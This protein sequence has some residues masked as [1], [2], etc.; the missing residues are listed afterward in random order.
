MELFGFF[1]GLPS[2]VWRGVFFDV[3]DR[4]QE[5]EVAFEPSPLTYTKNKNRF[6]KRTVR[7]GI[8]AA[9]LSIPD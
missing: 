5:L 2:W 8:F 6:R 1:A 3:L 9:G 7:R 4:P